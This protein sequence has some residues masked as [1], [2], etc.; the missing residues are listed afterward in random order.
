M[1]VILNA[2]V[3]VLAQTGMY[4]QVSLSGETYG[5]RSLSF[6]YFQN[7]T[8]PA[9]QKM[10]LYAFPDQE[11]AGFGRE[12]R[13]RVTMD[14]EPSSLQPIDWASRGK[15]VGCRA[16]V[17]T[18]EL[19]S[20]VTQRGVAHLVKLSEHTKLP[21]EI[22]SNPTDSQSPGAFITA[23]AIYEKGMGGATAIGQRGLR[24]ENLAQNAFEGMLD[25]M[26]GD[27]TVDPYL[28]DQLLVTACLASGESTFKT[29]RLTSRF[30]TSIWVIKQFLPIHITVRGT[31]D[32]P[33]VVSIKR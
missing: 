18:A 3:P 4:S 25:W 5:N 17:T 2:L 16:I 24:I 29:S 23:W 30:L 13:G 14:V 6:D 15:L 26:S 31:E 22:E 33:G 19:P 20:Y 9:L 28:A 7:V 32:K 1:P 8:I 27:A 21:L 11:L 10:G 12:S